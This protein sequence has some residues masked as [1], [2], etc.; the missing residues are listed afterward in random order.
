MKFKYLGILSKE[1]SEYWK[2]P[3]HKNKPILVFEDRKLHVIAKHLDDFGSKEEI[4]KIYNKLSLI[5]NKPDY[6]FYNKKTKGLEYY[7]KINANICV[8]V[9]ISTGKVLKVRSWYPVTEIKIKNRIKKD[10]SLRFLEM[11]DEKV[12]IG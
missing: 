4:E 12:T 6:V 2:L 8:A 10:E 7:K 5:I 1:I 11:E 3:N 9:R